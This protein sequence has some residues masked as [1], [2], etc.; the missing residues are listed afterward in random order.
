MPAPE[1]FFKVWELAEQTSRRC[2]LQNLHS[3]GNRNRWRDTQKQMDVIRLYL[4]RDNRPLALGANRV[5]NVPND[6]RNSSD[7][8]VVAILRAPN[9][10]VSCL[11]DTVPV[12]RNVNHNHIVLEKACSASPPFLSRLKSGVSWRTF[13][14]GGVV[15]LR[16]LR[17]HG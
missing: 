13:Y 9:H 2:T 17:R 16:I 4:F 6:L 1:S 15:L 10:M 14:E 3:I 7:Q 11:V 12:I 5:K 8:H